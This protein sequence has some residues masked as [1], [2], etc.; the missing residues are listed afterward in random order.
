M[1]KMK[2][3]LVALISVL[4]VIFGSIGIPISGFG[5]D[6][7]DGANS[8][9][10]TKESAGS[11]SAEKETVEDKTETSDVIVAENS[12]TGDFSNSLPELELPTIINDTSVMTDEEKLHFEMKEA[13]TLYIIDDI[14]YYQGDPLYVGAGDDA[15][16]AKYEELLKAGVS[17]TLNTRMSLFRAATSG[18]VTITF[19]GYVSAT[20]PAGYTSTVGDFR[21]NGQQV[22]CVQHHL[23]TPATGTVGSASIYQ[24]QQVANALYYGWGGPGNIF[25]N[26]SQGIVVTSLVLDRLI[27]GG[28]T[29]QTLSGYSSLWERVQNGNAP[30]GD[31]KANR[32]SSNTKISGEY[33]VSEDFV[34]TQTSGSD[35]YSINVPNGVTLINKTTGATTTNGTATV[36]TGEIFNFR[37]SLTYATKYTSNGIIGAKGAYQPIVVSVGGGYQDIGY[38]EWVQDSAKAITL[39]VNFEAKTGVGKVQKKDDN[40]NPV[41]GALFRFENLTTKETI[42]KRTDDNGFADYEAVNGHEIR[43]TEIEAPVGFLLLEN[44]TKT[45]TIKA[46]E[47]VTVD[48][49]NP[50]MN[51]QT[52]AIDNEDGD[53]ELSPEKK[54]TILDKISYTNLF[55]DGREYVVKG[56][57]MDKGTN[58]PLLVDGKEVTVEKSFVPEE[59]DGFVEVSFE[60]DASTLA[61]KT[62]VVFET[63]Y[64][65]EKEIVIHADIEDEEQTVIFDDPKIGTTA[66]NIEDD[67]KAF[68]PEEKVTLVDTVSFS[69]LQIGKKYKIEGILMSK[70]TK[71][72]LLIDEKEVTAEAE[73]TPETKDGTVEVIFEFDASELK[74]TELVVFE[75]LSRQRSDTGKWYEVTEHS[76]IN[77]RGQTVRITNPELQTSA[78]NPEDQTQLYDPLKEITIVDTVTYSDLVIGREYTIKGVLMDKE[79]NEPLI[80]NEEKVTAEAIFV[81]EAESGTI[82][83]AFTLDASELHGKQIVVFESLFKNDTEIATH[84]DIEDEGQTVEFTYPKIYTT[85]LDNDSES[86]LADALQ[87]ATITDIV[88]YEDLID[89]KQYT[90]TGILMDKDSGKPLTIDGEEISSTVTFIAREGEAEIVV[91]EDAEE[92]SEE[93]ESEGPIE[94]TESSDESSEEVEPDNPS[95]LANEDSEETDEEE[96]EDPR[97]NGKVEVAFTLNASEFQ[98]KDVVVFETL[99]REDTEIAVHAD[100]DDTGQTVHFNKP[101]LK[102]TATIEG[103]KSAEFSNKM[104][105]KDLIEYT[106]LTVGKEY[107][108]TGVLMDKATGKPFLVDGNEIISEKTFVADKRNGSI[109]VEF[110]FDGSGITSTTELVVFEDLYRIDQ[111]LATHSDI[112]DM[113]QTVQITNTPIVKKGSLPQTGEKKTFPYLVILLLLLAIVGLFLILYKRKHSE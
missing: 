84:A 18:N 65:D 17:A 81:A 95:D 110:V 29:G 5:I 66:S 54:V 78:I 68:D 62:I 105:I 107:T 6:I 79:S 33:Q 1:K 63:L 86:Q 49:I 82:E 47:T 92:A 57:L 90:L 12:E 24:N 32:T 85:A 77:D 51:I 48:F 20:N 28:T 53:K 19:L 102:T 71:E 40:G 97:V 16:P 21:V 45:I 93:P 42:E 46:G 37:A 35:T 52:A 104:V 15:V 60:L 80:V 55:T 4:M 50:K 99:I 38:A 27:S 10:T 36:K 58:E 23:P 56:I 76:D 111:L 106:N 103:E 14:L 98:G 74:G 64:Q 39:T 94:I 72:P 2:R 67:T 43:I 41:N 26:Q 44:Q 109:E 9:Q 61:G 3:K 7:V 91:L 30:T 101:A 22:F 87:E 31:I 83:L 100:I 13:E 70:D 108:V 89:G 96:A 8:E 113:N 112:N 73:F 69:D 59:K 75:Y 25:S 34:L 11:E 88:S